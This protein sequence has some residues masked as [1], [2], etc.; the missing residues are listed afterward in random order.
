MN[1]VCDAWEFDTPGK[2]LMS[3]EIART[4][5]NIKKMD[6]ADFEIGEPNNFVDTNKFAKRQKINASGAYKSND[7]YNREASQQQNRQMHYYKNQKNSEHESVFV[8][9]Y[10]KKYYNIKKNTSDLEPLLPTLMTDKPFLLPNPMTDKPF[11][12]G[13]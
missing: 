4:K 12:L 8:K 6:I 5:L 7:S 10:V 2:V 9:Q 11:F 1:H 3:A 13:K